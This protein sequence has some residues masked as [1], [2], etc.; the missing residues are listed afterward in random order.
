MNGWSP[1]YLESRYALYKADPGALDEVE[2]MFFAGF[3]LALA[4]GLK[5]PGAGGGSGSAGGSGS[6]LALARATDPGSVAGSANAERL[7]GSAGKVRLTP[8][9]GQPAGR[10]SPAQAVVDDFVTAYRQYG[11]LAAKID[12]FDRERPEVEELS[13]AY[14]GL[15]EKELDQTIDASDLGDEGETTLRALIERLERTYCGSI[16]VELMHI[17]ETEVRAWL[18]ERVERSG[19]RIQL[20]KQDKTKLLEQLTRAETF[21]RFLGKRYP[22]EKR[23]SLEGSESLIPLLDRVL[24][25]A[26][27]LDVEEIVLGMAHRGRLNVL[28]NILGKTYEQIFTEFEESWLED[29]DDSGGDVKYHKG[30]SGTRRYPN[31]RMLHLAMASNPSHLEAVGAVVLGRCRAKQRLRGDLERTRVMPLVMHGD[32]A[33][34]GQGIVAEI[35]NF[36]QLEGYTT[37][38][39]VHVVVNNQIGFTTL[40]EDARTSMYCTD[41][42]KIIEAPILHVNGEDPEAVVAAAKIA[43]EFRQRFKRDVFIDLQCYRKYGHNEQD[44]TS[45]TQPIL[46]SMIKKKKSVLD[47]YQQKLLDEGVIN[48]A[49]IQAIKLRMDEAL[50]RAQARSSRTRTTR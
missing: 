32:A 28:N 39:T 33:V 22:G 12:P 9:A 46:A 31:G 19:G 6:G 30:Y 43:T 14:H 35:L 21:E 13:L 4:D 8:F 25:T 34:I 2:R 37:G 5:M 29:F 16:G 17:N 18:V 50:E 44:E 42:A 41:V 11:H 40:P 3:D 27:D 36:S 10:T 24:E 23:F 1:E 15:S 49:D 45:F 48:Q 7:N 20:S 38:G 26:S 47:Q